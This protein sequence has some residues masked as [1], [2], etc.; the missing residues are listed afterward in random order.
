MNVTRRNFLK[1]SAFSTALLASGTLG[2]KN[3]NAEQKSAEYRLKKTKKTPTV[4]PFCSA[5]CGMLAYTDTSTGELIYV[6]GD[7]DHPVN[8]GGACSKGASIFQI[9]NFGPG[10]PN[11]KRLTKPLYRAPKSDKFQEVTWEWALTEIAK[12]TKDT[13][14]KNFIAQ[15]N[16]MPAMRTDAIACLGG[17]ALDNEECYILQKLMRGLGLVYIEH[18]ARL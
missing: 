2:A 18:Q 5:G 16:G 15:E 10:E 8:R 11:T 1:L 7:P 9:R 17:A 13:R 4:C 3:A 12:R 6:A 14:D